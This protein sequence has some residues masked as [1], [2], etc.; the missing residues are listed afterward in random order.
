MQT[1]TEQAPRQHNTKLL[2]QKNRNIC[3]VPPLFFEKGENMENGASSYLRFLNGDKSGFVDIVKEYNDRL[4]LFVDTI[5]NDMYISEEVIDDVF[6][7]LYTDRPVYKEKYSFKTWLYTIARN[8]AL[9][10]LKKIKRHTYSPIEDFCYISDT[11]DIEAEYIQDE[12]KILIHHCIKALNR[13]YADVLFLVYF[14]GLSNAE[15]AKII[16][17]SQRQI[18][19]L[20]YRAKKALK[21]EMERRSDI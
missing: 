3:A 18:T 1:D 4:I 20:L 11:V 6:L 14:E 2:Q 8:T 13:E 17:K 15:T 9:N 16:G 21:D 10:Y 5:I 19:Q 12:Q 7:R